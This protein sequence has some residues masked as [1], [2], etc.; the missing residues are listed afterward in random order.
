[1]AA[2]VLA[3]HRLCICIDIVLV[4]HNRNVLFYCR[5]VRYERYKGGVAS[6]LIEDA[7]LWHTHQVTSLSLQTR[8]GVVA[9]H[10]HAFLGVCLLGVSTHTP[11]GIRK[12][13]CF[14]GFLPGH[15]CIPPLMQLQLL[16]SERK[17]RIKVSPQS[18]S[19]RS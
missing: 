9:I 16:R 3:W 12:E 7:E 14:P 13:I 4:M 15:R 11:S 18:P 6:D 5:C 2:G 19:P 1:M 10:I 8:L 17:S